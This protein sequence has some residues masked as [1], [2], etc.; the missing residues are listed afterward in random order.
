MNGGTCNICGQPLTDASGHWDLVGKDRGINALPGCL[1]DEHIT[2]C[3]W[4][5]QCIDKA[6]QKI[7]EENREERKNW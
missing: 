6:I 3:S 7:Q 4:C 2:C 1:A 5:K